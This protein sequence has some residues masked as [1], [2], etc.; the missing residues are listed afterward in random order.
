MKEIK[1]EKKLFVKP[2]IKFCPISNKDIIATSEG[3]YGGELG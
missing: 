3:G 1:N 2:Q